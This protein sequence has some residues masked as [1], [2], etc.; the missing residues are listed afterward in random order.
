MPRSIDRYL[1]NDLLET[2]DP[3]IRNVI[4]CHDREDLQVFL[5]SGTGSLFFNEQ[6]LLTL[7]E[8]L[9]RNSNAS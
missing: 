2:L 7:L 4:V 9:R 5:G 6:D 8:F 3:D 1:S